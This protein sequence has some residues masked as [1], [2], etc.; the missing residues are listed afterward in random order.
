MS[1]THNRTSD[2]VDC[3]RI[4]NALSFISAQDR[5]TWVKIGMAIHSELGE[6]GFDLWDTWS[7]SA[8]SYKTRDARTVWKSFKSGGATTIGSLFHEAKQQGWRDTRQSY[9]SYHQPK[10]Q[11]VIQ[12]QAERVIAEETEI[13]Q[14]RANTALKATA[15]WEQANEA[16][17]DHPYLVRKQISPIGTL[18]EIDASVASSLLGYSPKSDSQPLIGRLLVVPICQDRQLSTLELI[19]EPGRKTVLAGRGS[20]TGGYWST[21]HPLPDLI[22]TVLIGEGVA[23]VLSAWQ[24]MEGTLG[25]ASLSSGNLSKVAQ[26]VREWYPKA[27]VVILADLVKTTG[28][29]DAHAIEA[30]RLVNGKLAIPNFG[31]DRQADQT[32]F[33]DLAALSDIEAVREAI[34]GAQDPN[35]NEWLEP[36]S[37][38]DL[39]SVKPFC[40]DYLPETLV[41]WIRDI[42]E[43]MQSPP[44]FSA[45]GSIVAISSLIGAKAVIQPKAKTD[46]QVTANLWGIAIGIPSAKK[47]PSL[48]K[49][50]APLQKLQCEE[51]EKHEQNIKQWN[52][53]NE[54]YELDKKQKTKLAESAIKKDNRD[55]AKE[56]LSNLALP[57]KPIMREFVVYDAT[58]EALGNTLSNYSW[59]T[60][61]YR[62]E[63]I[64]LLLSMDKEGQ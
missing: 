24:A 4:R 33:N 64:G 30:A 7:Q 27:D 5:A 31:K 49:V 23:T 20:K 12:H 45:I 60:L 13:A 50:L 63:L 9:T 39:P 43:L 53:E 34:D 32:D 56:L 6:S 16:K 3:N 11:K 36:I 21:V 10:A 29:P 25:I 19:D 59:G 28:E 44:D 14:E 15:I 57:T 22:S 58:V 47:S 26:Q 18:R 41:D 61:C 38:P 37:L 51:S 2:R 42:S 52:V 62:D 46:W 17:A 1:L 35:L 48:K 55:E 8:D 40:Y 54:I